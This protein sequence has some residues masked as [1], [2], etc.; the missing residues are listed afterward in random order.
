MFVVIGI[1]FLGI[2]LG[3]ALRRYRMGWL[4]R[5]ITLFIWALLFLLGVSVGGNS[6]II[7]ALPTIGMDALLITT[8]AVLGSVLCSW[9]LYSAFFKRVK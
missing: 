3:L 2:G 4:S 7:E 8:G 5:V 1:M 6:A 9:W